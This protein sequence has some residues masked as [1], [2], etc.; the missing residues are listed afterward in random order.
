MVSSISITHFDGS[1]SDG[2]FI[3]STADNF[4]NHLNVF[5]ELTTV[6][7][8]HGPYLLGSI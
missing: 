8:P 7:F 3:S 2:D 1:D 4:P 6:V 5:L